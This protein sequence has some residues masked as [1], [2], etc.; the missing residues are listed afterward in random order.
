MYLHQNGIL[1][2]IFA[3]SNK[4]YNKQINTDNYFSGQN[5]PTKIIAGY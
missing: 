1:K 5:P 4:S 3:A 2:N